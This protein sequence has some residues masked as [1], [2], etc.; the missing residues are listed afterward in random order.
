MRDGDVGVVQKDK[1]ELD[2]RRDG[3]LHSLTSGSSPK[4]VRAFFRRGLGPTAALSISSP[5]KNKIENR[6]EC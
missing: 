6:K 5:L 2:L 4:G 1:L 3:E